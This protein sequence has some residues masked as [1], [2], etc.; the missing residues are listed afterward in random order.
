MRALGL[1]VLFLLLPSS[2]ASAYTQADASACTPDALR[3]CA[4]YIPNPEAIE[5]CLRSNRQSLS[6]PC[7]VVF[8]PTTTA[9]GTPERPTGGAQ[10][11]QRSRQ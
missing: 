1:S 2:I 9:S 11:G 5:A 3:L 6:K 7:F 8:Q 10:G 4:R